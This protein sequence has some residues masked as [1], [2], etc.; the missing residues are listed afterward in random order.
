MKVK[1]LIDGAVWMPGSAYDV[2]KKPK[3]SVLLP[4]FR[5][6]KSGLFRHCV[7]SVLA[8]TLRDIELIIIDDASTDGT[9]D[10]IAEF[11]EQDGRVSCIRHTANVGLPAISE[12]EGYLKARADRFSF[13]FD[14]NVFK[15]DAFE[16]LLEESEKTPWALIY[17]HIE[18]G[19]KH[20]RTG[21]IVVTRLGAARSQGL[22]RT[23]NAIPNNAT[24]LPRHIIEDVG[25]YDPHVVMAR[26]CDWDLWVRVAE[27]YEIRF[28]DVAVGYEDG[29]LQ[30]DSLG[31]TYQLDSWA[32]NE[33]MDVDR[34]EALR[35]QNFAEYD[36]FTTTSITGQSTRTAIDQ[37]A[38]KHAGMRNWPLPAPVTPT[39]GA[40]SGYILV[41]TVH[42]D[43]S[44]TLCWE[45]LPESIAG[46][47]RVLTYFGGFGVEEI[48][49]ATAIVFVRQMAVFEPWIKAAKFAGVP[50]YFYLDDNLPLLAE[51]GELHVETDNYRPFIFRDQMKQF[52]GVLLSSTQLVEYFED[53]M[54][55]DN[56]T[57]FPVS[58]VNQESLEPDHRV[59]RQKY[60]IVIASAGGRHRDQGLWE[61]VFP[62]LKKLAEE[63]A[64]IH[65]VATKPKDS[66]YDELIENP[67][68][69]IR[70]TTLEFDPSYLFAMRR[71][72]RYS[73]DFMIHPPADSENNAFKTLNAML[74]AR[75]MGAV[76][77][78][79]AAPPFDQIVGRGNAVVVDDPLKPMS[80][81][82]SLKKAFADGFDH[83]AIRAANVEFCS[84][85]FSGDANTKALDAILKKHGG[86][87][88]IYEQS[89]RL[90]RLASAIRASGGV[91]TVGATPHHSDEQA[92]EM[93][94][95]RRMVRYS[96]RH[97]ILRRNTDL[98]DKVSL[99][100]M[101]IKKASEA[102]G[103]RRFGS[104]LEL[105]DSLHDIPYREYPVRMPS[106][107]LKSIAFALSVDWGRRGVVGIEL[108]GPDETIRDH[109]SL[110]IEKII[111][112]EP[113]RFDLPN[114]KIEDG[115]IWK[116]RVFANSTT[117]IYVFEFIN[118]RF[119]GLRFA[120][121]TPF[122]ELIIDS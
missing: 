104:S 10:Q 97:R 49:R 90:H 6:A 8:Q 93:A 86:E 55:H 27:R 34:N 117:P 21:E 54:F 87:A 73:P 72:A 95:L 14:D 120:Q 69:G 45:M 85:E 101:S 31:N 20:G 79:P 41:V 81:Y 33:W 35:P 43:A 99:N 111:L 11:M 83:D 12:Y 68:E 37:L 108:V 25:F 23:G 44:T 64:L 98:W 88:S 113:V 62:A 22:L 60:E 46:K 84:Q 17:G 30:Q 118:R 91:T 42:Y 13:A 75:L 109:V 7:E 9:A 29:A 71:F 53:Q 50:V 119:M 96:W 66:A 40:H 110:D 47:V 1:D 16:L 19:Y 63:G 74:S 100:F 70:I 122:M 51:K 82:R 76:A 3:V 24:M 121:P 114:I 116:V 94:A 105:S 78:V 112:S 58:C 26:I 59:A 48:A 77:V 18:F 36:V 38:R 102:A 92:M 89:R 4:T 32:V 52:E 15:E 80:W 61:K 103:W 57:Y 115:E 2:A 39:E 56:L 106:G 5:R 107:T 67:P 28:V 65:I